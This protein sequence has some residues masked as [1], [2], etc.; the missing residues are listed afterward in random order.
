MSEPKDQ[1]TVTPHSQQPLVTRTYPSTEELEKVILSSADAQKQWGKVPL[2][3][4]ITI[5]N[6]FIVS[7]AIRLLPLVIFNLP[8]R[9]RG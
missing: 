1:T 6:K 9:L 2:S 3:D 7:A 5:A 4:R 8:Y